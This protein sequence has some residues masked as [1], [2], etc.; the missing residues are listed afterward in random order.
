MNF[1]MECNSLSI[2]GMDD[3][4]AVCFG[5]MEK[6]ELSQYVMLQCALKDD[7]LEI[8]LEINDQSSSVYGGIIKCNLD[9]NSLRLEL[10]EAAAVELG[11]EHSPAELVLKLDLSTDEIEELSCALSEVIF[12]GSEIFDSSL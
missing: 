6:E 2:T 10:S 5:Y 7:N 4:L 1:Y 3:S 12:Q 11:L 8:Y 9:Q